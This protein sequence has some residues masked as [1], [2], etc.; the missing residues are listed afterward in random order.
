MPA[1]AQV[2]LCHSAGRS[3]AS[4]RPELDPA[5]EKDSTGQLSFAISA[6][7]LPGHGPG[8]ACT[9][10]S[11]VG[12]ISVKECEWSRWLLRL[13][14]A[15]GPGRLVVDLSRLSAMDWW[16]ALM[17]SWVGRVVSRRGVMLVLASPQP[18]VARLLNA[19]DVHE[20][21]AVYDGIQSVQAGSGEIG[22]HT[23]TYGRSNASIPAEA[24]TS[25]R[26]L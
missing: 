3:A 4:T 15:Q 13:D 10:V 5:G 12:R 26:I 19:L 2:S 21:V 14:A 20:V 17:F 23:G 8:A 25:S 16:T 18:T 11:L 24:C 7:A 1:Q 22:C 6:S 9:V